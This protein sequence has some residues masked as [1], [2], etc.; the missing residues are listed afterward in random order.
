LFKKQVVSL[1]LSYRFWGDF[2]PKRNQ[3]FLRSMK[4]ARALA[5]AFG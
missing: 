5:Q 3:A 4:K 2:S 1:F